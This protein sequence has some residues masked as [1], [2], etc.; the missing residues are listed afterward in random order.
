M[1]KTQR[2]KRKKIKAGKWNK[3]KERKKEKR[4]AVGLKIQV[5]AK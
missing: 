2:N 1:R 4:K 3:K 5:W